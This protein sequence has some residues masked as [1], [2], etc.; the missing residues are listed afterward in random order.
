MTHPKTNTNVQE[1]W[2]LLNYLCK[3]YYAKLMKRVLSI[4]LLAVACLFIFSCNGKNPTATPPS[5]QGQT[6]ASAP[7]TAQAKALPSMPSTILALYKAYCTVAD[8]ESKTDSILSVYCTDELRKTIMEAF[9]EYDVL[10]SGY[11]KS[12]ILNESLRVARKNEKYVVY[13]EYTKLPDSDEPGKDSVYVMVNK[14]NKIW[15]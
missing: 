9:G 5:A 3:N 2:V 14:D 10:L 6:M 11:L 15:E 4:S 13:F 1:W 7:A 12:D 8:G